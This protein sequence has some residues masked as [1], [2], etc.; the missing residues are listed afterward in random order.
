MKELANLKVFSI[1]KNKTEV[2]IQL[3]ISTE[4]YKLLKLHYLDVFLNT[5]KETIFSFLG[6]INLPTLINEQAL[7]CEGITS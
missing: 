3:E 7:E 5:S 2:N 4:L 6:N 1:F